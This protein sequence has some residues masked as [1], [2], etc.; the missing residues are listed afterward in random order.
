MIDS[1]NL[2]QLIELISTGKEK[3][4]IKCWKKK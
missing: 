1:R 4:P 3:G 2:L